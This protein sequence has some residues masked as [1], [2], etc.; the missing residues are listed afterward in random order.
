MK[1]RRHPHGWHRIADVPSGDSALF[2]KIRRWLGLA[3]PAPEPLDRVGPA[4]IYGD[5]AGAWGMGR[6]GWDQSTQVLPRTAPLMTLAGE[7][8]SSGRAWQL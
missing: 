3:R 8:R 7:W 1:H 4:T 5:R 2:T 6:A